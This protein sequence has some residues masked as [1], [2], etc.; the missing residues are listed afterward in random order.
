M[1]PELKAALLR[2]LA[3]AATVAAIQFF[4]FWTHPK[5]DTRT[6]V[7]I[8][9]LPALTMLGTRFFGEGFMDARSAKAAA[10]L[11]EQAEVKEGTKP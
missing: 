6:L 1:T 5:I 11:A 4:T 10:A 7:S 3:H 9:L 2:G 8:S